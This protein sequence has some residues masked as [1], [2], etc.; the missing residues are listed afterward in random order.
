MAPLSE[1]KNLD[2]S[3]FLEAPPAREEVLVIDLPSILEFS[4][5]E[6][7][8]YETMIQ[9][10]SDVCGGRD[11]EVFLRFISAIEHALLKMFKTDDTEDSE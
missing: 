9:A 8:I 10:V 3:E 4:T 6:T 11:T 1:L 7:L 2:D 5:K